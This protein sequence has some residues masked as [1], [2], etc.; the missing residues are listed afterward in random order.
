ML[1]NSKNVPTDLSNLNSKGDKYLDKLVPVP[2][3]L[4][5]LSD[6]V[7][8]TTNST[9]NAKINEVNNVMRNITNLATFTPLKAKKNEVKNKIPIINTLDT[10]TA[11]T[12]VEN[13]VPSASNLV[14]KTDYR[15]NIS[16]TENKI[17]ADHDHDKYIITQK[18]KLTG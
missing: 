12:T 14:K 1:I 6:I 10:T 4:R 16:E 5:K 17:T 15:T 13:K 11:L 9:L 7:I 2:V 8:L 3:D 18:L